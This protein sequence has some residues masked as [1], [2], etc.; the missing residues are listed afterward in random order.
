[1]S[2]ENHKNTGLDIA[3]LLADKRVHILEIAAQHG[4]TMY[5]FLVQ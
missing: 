4:L 3:D 5:E 2:L 1:M